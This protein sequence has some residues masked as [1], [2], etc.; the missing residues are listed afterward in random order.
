MSERISKKIAAIAEVNATMKDPVKTIGLTL[1]ISE[2]N[3]A[4]TAAQVTSVTA[5]IKSVVDAVV[6]AAKATGASGG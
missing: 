4:P 3:T 2:V 6:D 5:T 1:V